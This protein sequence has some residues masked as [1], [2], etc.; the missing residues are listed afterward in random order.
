MKQQNNS[1]T[2]P[3]GSFLELTKAGN[4]ADIEKWISAYTPENPVSIFLVFHIWSIQKV[5]REIENLF[6]SCVTSHPS[7][8]E[9][10]LGSPSL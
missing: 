9:S 3:T 10:I 8:L 2:I 1:I 6:L 4:W 7:S 5:F